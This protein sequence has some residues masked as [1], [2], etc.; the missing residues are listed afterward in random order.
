MVMLSGIQYYTGQ[1]FDIATITEAGQQVVLASS[2]VN[3][4]KSHK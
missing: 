1:L 4:K 3:Q 2:F